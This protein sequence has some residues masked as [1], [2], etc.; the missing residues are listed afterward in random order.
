MRLL[1]QRQPALFPPQYL[2]EQAVA[3]RREREALGPIPIADA[4]KLQGEKDLKLGFHEVFG[5]LYD[6]LGLARLWPRNQRGAE[7][8]FR[9]L[10]LARLAAP[11]KS[12]RHLAA[13][14]SEQGVNLPLGASL[15]DDGSSESAP[16]EPAAEAFGRDR[17]GLAGGAGGSRLPGHDDA[18]LRDRSGR[19][20]AT[21]GIQ[22]GRERDGHRRHLRCPCSSFSRG[23]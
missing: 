18:L 13:E 19:R 23:Y 2:A 22:Q 17:P 5:Q 3:A 8:V 20:F 1:Q 7:R 14:L 9:Q 16:T 6:D 21:Q 11:G 12:K 15:P 10:V 4:R